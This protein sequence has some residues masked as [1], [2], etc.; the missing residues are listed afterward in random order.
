MELEVGWGLL[1]MLLEGEG[2]VGLGGR[3]CIESLGCWISC[4]PIEGWG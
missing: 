3:S 1:G 4:T 2:L